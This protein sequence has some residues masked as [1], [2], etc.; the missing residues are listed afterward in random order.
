MQDVTL[1][2]GGDGLFAVVDFQFGEDWADVQSLTSAISRALPI[3]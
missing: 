2:C 3:S 1:D